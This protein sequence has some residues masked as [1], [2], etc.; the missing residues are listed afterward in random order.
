MSIIS[1]I[2]GWITMLFGSKIAGEFDIKPITSAEVDN[3]IDLCGRI[4]SGQPDWLDDEDGVRT[5]NF[6]KTICSEVAR[7]TTL[8][9]GI[10]VAGF[11]RAD[12]L[13]EQ[14]E[15]VYFRLRHWIEYGCA[16]GT[17]ILKYDGEDVALYTPQNFAVTH[18][19]GGNIDG[20]VFADE[21]QV[22]KKRYT[23]LEHHRFDGSEYVVTNR[24][25][26]K[27]SH[28]EERACGIER[29]PWENLAEETRIDNL[30]RPL[31]AVFRTPGA[32]HIDAA[33][34]YALPIFSDALQELMDLDVAY[35]RM[36][37]ENADSR[38]TVL[39]DTDR[40][41]PD[42]GRV[43]LTPEYFEHRRKSL[44]L[45][46]YIKAVEGNGMEPFYKEI[47]PTIQPEARRTA[48]NTQL[49][50]IGYK[51]GFSPGYF[52]FDSKNGMITATQVEAEDR[53]TIQLVKD[54]RDKAEDCLDGL[55]YTMNVFADLY[56]LA[57]AGK[58]EV[59]YDF[60]DVTYNREE[61]RVR[62][63]GYVT[64]GKVPF[65]RYLM[66]FEGYT[67]EEAKAVE[68]EAAPKVP[69]LFGGEE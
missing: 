23:K 68:A 66:K 29:T 54:T 27:D 12:W 32:N 26:V 53:R 33:S 21:E 10:K 31:F 41:L 36:A 50:L 43:Q 3:M 64:A 4:Y 13:Q 9:I 25:F 60:G 11:A 38:R 17:V 49:G 16:Y 19:T 37:Q 7:L 18:Q 65:W 52:A 69:T 35:S 39:L 40:L 22:G 48:L 24:C 20:V 2:K 8:G 44:G 42:G 62:W 5:I 55:I 34:P 14:V 67:E 1:T 56:E 63:F 6:A 61:D 46:R 57:P 45:P 28:G 47:N 51:L 30:T 58:Y 59:I 15:R